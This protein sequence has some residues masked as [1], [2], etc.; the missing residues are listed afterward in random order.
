MRTEARLNALRSLPGAEA[1]LAEARARAGAVPPDAPDPAAIRRVGV[2][3]AGAM[4]RG[5]AMAFA[6][7]GRTVVLADPA[8][9]ARAAARAHLTALADRQRAKGRLDDAGHAALLA[10]ITLAQGVDAFAGADLAVEAVPEVL[11]LKQAVLTGIEAALPPGA[12]ITSNTSTLDVDALAGAL[13][14]P[15]RFI[16]THFF[17][18]AQVNRL[19]ELV[20]SSRTAPDTL[21]AA[22]AL[23]RD[24]GKSAAIAANGDGFIGNRLFDRF[25]HEAM[26]VVEEGAWPEEVDAA[27][28]DW[29]FAIGPFRALDMV[30]NDIPWGVRVQRAARP[31]PPPQPRVGDALCEAGLLGQKV[32]RGWYFYDAVTPRGRPYEEARALILR[33]SRALG[34]TRRAIGAPEIVGRCLVALMVEGLAMLREGRAARPSDIDVVQVTGY[35]FPAAV[36]GPM[37]LAEALGAG[38]VLAQAREYGVLSGRTDAIWALPAALMEG[39]TP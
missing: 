6:G 35:G 2:L 16:G 15:E 21:A 1:Y 39:P 17:M 9:E 28:E 20:P 14:H 11:T 18:P 33:V 34:R 32:G 7:T 37:R 24:L 10:R 5:I 13:R 31:D 26:A 36:G 23:A 19:L 12:L 8:P 38:P 4:G 30:G 29:G 27:L 3:G 22:L 25:H